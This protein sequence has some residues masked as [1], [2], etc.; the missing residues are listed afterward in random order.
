MTTDSILKEWDITEQELTALVRDNPSLRGMMLGYIAEYKFQHIYLNNPKITGC[1]KDD[2]HDR[3][4]KGDRR[5]V[6]KGKTFIIEVKSLQSK[7][8]KQI[9]EDK[10]QGKA[11]VD[12]SDRRIIK[13]KDGTELNTTLLERG[14]FD[15][16][17]VNCFNFGNKWR[18][19]F[20][21][22]SDLPT[23]S[24]AKYTEAQR[25]KLIASLVSVKWP[26]TPPFTDDLFKLL[27]S[28]L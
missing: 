27:D 13:F 6:Y 22:N 9:D 26:P 25:K 3:T 18:F 14:E 1:V 24:F 11:Q 17:A 8:T 12:G 20:C 23:S 2:D 10:W 15:V 19:L 16:L 7:M 4:K 28:M 5:I 21:K